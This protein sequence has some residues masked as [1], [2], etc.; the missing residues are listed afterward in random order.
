MRAHRLLLGQQNENKS[1][2]RGLSPR[3]K[4]KRRLRPKL[5]PTLAGRVCCLVST[6]DPYSSIL[7]FSRPNPPLVLPSTSSVVLTSLNGPRSRPTISQKNLVVKEIE[8]E[9]SGSVVKNSDH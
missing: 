1:K 5:L 4:Y 2:L 9:T 7:R 6:T 8:P 3:V